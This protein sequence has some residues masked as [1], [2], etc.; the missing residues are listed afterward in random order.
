MQE[1]VA[2]GSANMGGDAQ[3]ITGEVGVI[4]LAT[5]KAP[6]RA[7]AAIRPTVRSFRTK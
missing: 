3:E 7:R 1:R 4:I 6:A 5:A 2:G